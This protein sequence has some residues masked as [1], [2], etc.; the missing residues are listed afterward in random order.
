[1][2][3]LE[4]GAPATPEWED[5]VNALTNAPRSGVAGAPPSK[6]SRPKV[7]SLAEPAARG[8]NSAR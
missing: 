2:L 6:R 4:G 1:M 8:F 7:F 3:P 5:D